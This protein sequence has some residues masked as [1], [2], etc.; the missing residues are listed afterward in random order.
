VGKK[1]GKEGNEEKKRGKEGDE[2]KRVCHILTLF[3]GRK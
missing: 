1:E 3:S 2:E